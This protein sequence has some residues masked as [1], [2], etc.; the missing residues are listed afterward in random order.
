MKFDGCR[1]E[2]QMPKSQMNPENSWQAALTRCVRRVTP[3]GA[4]CSRVVFLRR[5]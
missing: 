2:T 4:G 3:V 1:L 5:V